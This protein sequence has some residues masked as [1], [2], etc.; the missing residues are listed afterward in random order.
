[1]WLLL[2]GRGSFSEFAYTGVPGQSGNSSEPSSASQLHPSLQMQ[3]AGCCTPAWHCTSSVPVSL[4]WGSTELHIGAIKGGSLYSRFALTNN[5]SP[6]LIHRTPPQMFP[7]LYTSS[8]RLTTPTLYNEYWLLDHL[9]YPKLAIN[10]TP[11]RIF[12]LLWGWA[13][14]VAFVFWS[15]VS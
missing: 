8:Y 11:N 15:R 6:Q 5:F 13:A 7:C 14:F 4:S 12:A 2:A 1:M 3:G 10:L 9:K